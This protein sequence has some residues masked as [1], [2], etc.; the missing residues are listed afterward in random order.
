MTYLTP[1]EK[2]IWSAT[3]AT[4]W[5]NALARRA[6]HGVPMSVPTCI[7]NAWAAVSEARG[8]HEAVKDGWGEADAV[9]LV[10]KQMTQPA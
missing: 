7:E 6:A 3:Y 5:S 8:A 10:L 1:T 2:L 4:E 9:Y